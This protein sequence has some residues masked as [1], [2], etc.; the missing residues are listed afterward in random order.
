MEVRRSLRW[1]TLFISAIFSGSV[2]AVA[3]VAVPRPQIRALSDV[4]LAGTFGD[5]CTA[6]VSPSLC[7]TA[8]VA[9]TSDCAY[10]DNPQMPADPRSVCCSPSDNIGEMTTC[11]YSG[12]AACLN[13]TLMQGAR[14]GGIGSCGSCTGAFKPDGMCTSVTDAKGKN[15][16]GCNSP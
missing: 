12:P 10:C 4:Q 3:K 16:M 13:S 11:D 9:G 15:C 5:G 7:A 8:Y 2:L 6:C 14:S 1:R